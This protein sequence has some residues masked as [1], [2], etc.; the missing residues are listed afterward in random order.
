MLVLCNRYL[1]IRHSYN[2]VVIQVSSC[3]DELSYYQ[4]KMK[5]KGCAMKRSWRNMCYF[6]KCVDRVRKLR[7]DAL[8]EIGHGRLRNVSQKY[9]HW[10]SSVRLTH[11]TVAV[12][13]LGNS[14]HQYVFN[15]FHLVSFLRNISKTFVYVCKARRRNCNNI[16]YEKLSRLELMSERKRYV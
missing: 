5:M 15:Q 10:I 8:A 14:K 1:F 7:R 9:Y 3:T 16:K 11:N 4:W 12:E 6:V 2:F 13:F